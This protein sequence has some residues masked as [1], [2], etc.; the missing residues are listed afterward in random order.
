MAYNY[1]DKSNIQHILDIIYRSRQLFTIAITT[2]QLFDVLIDNYIEK[3]IE[4]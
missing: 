4:I 2:I 1:S 3:I